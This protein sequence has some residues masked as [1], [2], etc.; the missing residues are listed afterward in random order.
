MAWLISTRPF[1]LKCCCSGS[2]WARLFGGSF[3]AFVALL[4]CRL[5]ARLGAASGLLS[6]FRLLAAAGLAVMLAMAMGSGNGL[7]GL[8][9]LLPSL[10]GL[11][12]GGLDVDY[13][14]HGNVRNGDFAL[15]AFAF[16]FFRA[17]MFLSAFSLLLFA[18]LFLFTA[19]CFFL[20]AICLGLAALLLFT[21]ALA[22]ALL[23]QGNHDLVA[24]YNF[25]A[26]NLFAF[27]N[28]SFG[29]HGLC[30]QRLGHAEAIGP[31]LQGIA[32]PVNDLSRGCS[33][34]DVYNLIAI[35][36]CQAMDAK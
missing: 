4:F 19:L 18:A 35:T 14:L 26:D 31:I 9:G 7:G 33:V 21:F 24:V 29:A 1:W 30:I 27:D 2:C 36:A 22:A 3:L 13:L 17:F 32:K 16:M 6:A 28:E 12:F 5:V 25:G 10:D 15:L 23:L 20:A 8:D 34:D 11:S